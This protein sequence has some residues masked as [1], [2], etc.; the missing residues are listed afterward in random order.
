MEVGATRRYVQ[1]YDNKI[2]LAY[3]DGKAFQVAYNASN[4][5]H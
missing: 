4:R 3:L 1:R 2:W 5:F